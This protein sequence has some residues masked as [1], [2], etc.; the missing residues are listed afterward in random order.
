M[1]TAAIRSTATSNKV[2]FPDHSSYGLFFYPDNCYGF[3]S[4]GMKMCLK[5][6]H[7]GSLKKV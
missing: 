5:N 1:Q 6:T 3:T 2:F 7:Y 4:R